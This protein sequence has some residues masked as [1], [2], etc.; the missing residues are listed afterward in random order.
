MHPVC[1]V[2]IFIIG[3]GSEPSLRRRTGNFVSLCMPVCGVYI[4][5]IGEGSEPS[6]RRRTGNFVSLCMPGCGVYIIYIYLFLLYIQISESMRKILRLDSK[7]SSCLGDFKKTY[8]AYSG[9]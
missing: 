8:Q 2:Y 5:I 4:F 6:L 9:F 7:G 3:E 1:G